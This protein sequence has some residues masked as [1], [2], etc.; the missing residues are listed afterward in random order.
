[1]LLLF[2]FGLAIQTSIALDNG[3]AL[4]PPM[5]W[6][7]WERFRCNTDCANDPENC[8]S[9][10]LYMDMADRIAQDGY[11][12]LGYE[13]VIIDDCWLEME[14]DAQGKLQ[15][16]K[17]RFPHGIKSLADYVH[18]K[19]LKFG[20]Y[21]D[22]G[23]KTCAGYPGIIG[24]IEQDAKTFAEWEVDYVKLDG[25]NAD[26]KTMDTGY[27]EMGKHMNA[28]GRPMV[29][30]C[31]WPDYQ[32]AEGMKPNYTLIAEHCN[33]WRN[34]DDIDDSW[35]SVKSIID[36]YSTNQDVLSP[37]AAP[38]QW[39]DPDM[40][41]I[42]NFGLSFDQA[43]AQMAI[44]SIMASPL[45]MSVDL[46]SIKDEFKSILQN[47]QVIAV[48]QDT[49]GIQGKLVLKKQNIDVWTKPINPTVHGSHSYAVVFLNHGT[50]GM[51]FKI[52]TTLRVSEL[53]IGVGTT[54]TMNK[55]Q[56]VDAER[57]R[58]KK[59]VLALRF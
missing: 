26:P 57:P 15:A 40:L 34:F 39:N 42:G 55:N 28:T 36:Y 2:F 13:Y 1:M 23:T 31:S 24:H 51:P 17:T 43:K 21:E 29:Y 41:I 47:K 38:G 30:S 52:T 22:Y 12:E 46:R 6:L 8:I 19:G 14:R 7:S 53:L 45:I 48:N 3:L 58:N 59:K 49:L 35:T 18:S 50:D 11:K 9:E 32:R 16:D 33:L 37:A 27:P 5:G 56:D 20:I 10:R 54:P 4:T 44:W 25:C